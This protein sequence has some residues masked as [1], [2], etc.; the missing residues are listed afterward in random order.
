MNLIWLLLQSSWRSVA[1]AILTGLIS[2]G[3]SARLIALINSAVSGNVTDRLLWYF[4]GLAGIA[5]CTSVISQVLLIQLAQ[6]A[7]YDLRLRL[8]RGIL[9]SPLRHLESLGAN[10]LLA[11]LTE[12]V[13][14]LSRTIFVIPFICIDIAVIVGCLIYLSWL[15]GAVFL[16]TIV[17]LGAAIATTQFMLTQARKFLALA[18]EEEDHLF[19]HFRTITDG[20]KE[21][22][23]HTVRR[24]TFLSNDLQTSAAASRQHNTAA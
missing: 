19:K 5:L 24:Q 21:L 7:V 6:E 23:L 9:S 14:T 18:R 2:G 15:S 16:V 10:R 20:I 13:Q 3:C 8:S 1:V 22:K 17:F 12:D 4:I 11:T